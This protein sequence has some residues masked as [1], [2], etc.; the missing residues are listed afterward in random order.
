MNVLIEAKIYAM[1]K[2]HYFSAAVH[3][4]KG[5]ERDREKGSFA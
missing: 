3:S 2:L 4:S 5:E 1:H